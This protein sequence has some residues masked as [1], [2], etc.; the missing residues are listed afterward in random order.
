[1]SNP[2]TQAASA[3]CET[4]QICKGCIAGKQQKTSRKRKGR[5]G[6]GGWNYPKSSEPSQNHHNEH[7]KYARVHTIHMHAMCIMQSRPIL[8]DMQI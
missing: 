5:R 3:D 2:S 4:D 7:A 6:G 8:K 1:M